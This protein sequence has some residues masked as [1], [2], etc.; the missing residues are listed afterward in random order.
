MRVQFLVQGLP[1]KKDGA[2]SMWRKRAEMPRLK[3]L[4]I[5]AAQA[6]Q[7][8]LLQSV[9]LCL[10]LHIHAA[11]FDGDL[12]N[13]ITGVCDGL[14]PAHHNTPIIPGEW[15]DVPEA[16]R[17]NH[18]IAFRDDSVITQIVAE[19]IVSDA[20]QRFYEVEIESL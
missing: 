19:R 15:Q 3:A 18:A 13:F 16:A 1:P 8:I 10:R 9:P 12:D 7:G 20:G 5:A 17:P 6:M 11:V 4:R 14:M 2:N